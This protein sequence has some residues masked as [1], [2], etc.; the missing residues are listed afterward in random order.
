MSEKAIKLTINKRPGDDKTEGKGSDEQ[1]ETMP[2]AFKTR[3]Q[4]EVCDGEK[5]KDLWM[6]DLHKGNLVL[7]ASLHSNKYFL[8]FTKSCDLQTSAATEVFWK[9]CERLIVPFCYHGDGEPL[10][11]E[12]VVPRT[13]R[14]S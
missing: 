3:T 5:K 14:L 10:R 1:I 11:S 2:T 7:T 8:A 12:A 4:A 9:Q 13:L 6:K